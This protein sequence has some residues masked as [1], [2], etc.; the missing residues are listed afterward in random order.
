MNEIN[1]LKKIDHPNIMRIIEYYISQ[2]HIYIVSE[3]LTGGELFDR[4]V[5]QQHFTEYMAAV[6]I[7]QILSAV[8]YLHQHKIIHRDLKP[9]NIVFETKDPNSQLKIIDFGTCRKL[10]ETEK[11]HS[12]LGTAY[13]IAPEVLNGEYDQKCDIWSC[14]VILYIFLF[15]I[16]PFNAKT[17]EEIF[18]K[19]KKG[20]FTFPPEAKGVS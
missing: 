11:L 20:I 9:E 16:P 12:R 6:Y 10:V 5:S 14:G 4:I 8:S 2:R 19:I 15:G 18:S 17:D 3:Y 1:I 13:Y 7:K